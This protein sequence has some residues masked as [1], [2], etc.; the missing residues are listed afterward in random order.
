MKLYVY[1]L[2]FIFVFSFCAFAQEKQKKEKECYKE[3]VYPD[4][5]QTLF[6]LATL[7]ATADGVRT[8]QCT[9]PNSSYNEV[10]EAAK[11]VTQ[12]F[13]RIGKRPI[14]IDESKGKISNS[15][16]EDSR[17]K[18][19]S[20]IG[21]SWIDEIVTE[22]IQLDDKNTKVTVSRRV[23]QIQTD[24]NGKRVWGLVISNG[25]VEK[26]LLSKIYKEVQ[27]GS[28]NS[29]LGNG[30]RSQNSVLPSETN[31][32]LDQRLNEL[33]EDISNELVENG[34]KRVAIADFVDLN[35][36]SSDFGKYL[37]EELITR[38]F[39]EKSRFKVVERQRLDK[40][41]AEQKL[42]LTGLID[43]KLAQTI[44][45]ILGVQS[46]VVGTISDIG[47]NFKINARIIDA[48]TG[49]VFAASSATVAKDEEVC[50]L[51]NCTSSPNTRKP[52]MPSTRERKKDKDGFLI[53]EGDTNRNISANRRESN[54]FTFD[55][56]SCRL[57]GAS[58]LC[59]IF[60]TNTDKDREIQISDNSQI[61][62][63]FGNKS[64][65]TKIEIANSGSYATLIYGVPVKVRLTFTGVSMETTKITKLLIVARV[66]GSGSSFDVEYRNLT[67][68]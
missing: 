60:I 8:E 47:R 19:A 33:K 31:A 56:Q 64:N 55:L 45:K 38:F 15:N 16:I 6:S 20:L 53:L 51:I 34:Q 50:S 59:E 66:S 54:F 39:K 52:D 41:I 65:R 10:W 29:N 40:V 35:G 44:G 62:D 17:N 22:V 42:S 37:A 68:R 43:P 3:L 28:G 2:L 48:G 1:S 27:E 21:V 36:Q 25:K 32:S 12:E 26:W 63:D 9:I 23:L 24:S 57:S 5:K 4:G 30:N 58:V 13:T 7:I 11:R 61:F 46:I 18:E 14:R 49:E 67:L